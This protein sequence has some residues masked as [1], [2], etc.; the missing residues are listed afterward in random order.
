M[1]QNPSPRHVK[2][3]PLPLDGHS[4][5]FTPTAIHSLTPPPSPYSI[6]TQP[7]TETSFALKGRL[8]GTAS[9]VGGNV[10]EYQCDSN[11]TNMYRASIGCVP[12][13]R[14]ETCRLEALVLL[15]YSHNL[16]DAQ[17][18]IVQDVASAMFRKFW[19]GIE[20]ACEI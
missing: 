1:Q 6:P 9:N 5:K 2:L 17:F 18:E 15:E 16:Q 11:Q 3:L 10:G 4:S 8:Y 12:R 13:L 14:L 19:P 7:S 20:V